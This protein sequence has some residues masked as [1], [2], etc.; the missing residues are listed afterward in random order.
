MSIKYDSTRIPLS[1][2]IEN[3]TK[4][5]TFLIPDL[6]RPYVWTPS[7]VIILIDS[8]FK[9]WPFGSLLLW[10]V[11]QDCYKEN[12]GIPHRPFW[13]VTDRTKDNDSSL[14][15][16][17]AQ[18]AT[19]HMVLDGQQRVQSLVLAL[20][21]DTWGF[22]LYDH[23]WADDLRERRM[24]NNI[25]W[26]MA[27]LC[28]DLEKFL[29]ELNNTGNKVRKI[30][31]GKILDWVIPDIPNSMS[32]TNRP[33]ANYDH[34]L[35]HSKNNSGRFIRLS[36]LWNEVQ[37]DLSEG[38]Y[39]EIIKP[40][41]VEH[42]VS[43]IDDILQPLAEFLKNIET[44][45][46]NSSVHVLKI[47]SFILTAQW[48]KD[49]YN[50][51]IVNIFTRLNTAGRTLTRE[52]ITLAWLKVG[53][54]NQYTNGKNA[55]DCF[56]KFILEMNDLGFKLDMD[57]V[58]RL[59]S[60]I[61]SVDSR[62]GQLLD[63]KD[64]LNGTL[65]RSMA[66]FLAVNWLKLEKCLIEGA[67]ILEQRNLIEVQGAFNAV[68]VYLT[69]YYYSKNWLDKQNGLI[70]VDR[71][72][73]EKELSKLS[74]TFADRWTFVSQWAGVWGEGSVKNFSNFART[75]SSMLT[76]LNK[77]RK[78]NALS[79]IIKDTTESLLSRVSDRAIDSINNISVRKRNRVHDYSKILWVWHRLEAERWEK[80][81]IQLRTGR[82]RTSKNEV[83]HT[84]ADAWW[85]NLIDSAMTEKLK[86]F[87]GTEEE[88][89]LIGP[90]GFDDEISAR[91]FINRL[92][93]CSLLDKSF[94]ISKS[95][96]TFWGFLSE[97]H[98]FKNG[99]LKRESWE[100]A[101]SFPPELTDPTNQPYEV[102]V[103]KI[104]ERDDLMKKEVIEF[105]K[106]I[107]ERHDL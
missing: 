44:I 57:D 42:S 31:V 52:E 79:Q 29:T 48:T 10:E 32:D 30:E 88:K 67:N 65:I 47:E 11:K 107:K 1:E 56:D 89:L 20:G 99:I 94:N 53:W 96:G 33:V 72:N 27:T 9:G 90:D 8:L 21:G 46:N 66:N 28:V 105:I 7:Q 40:I 86:S 2:I 69:W 84:V 98:D 76:E 97:V 80:S 17:M 68:I 5:A 3:A 12:E 92:G 18:P 74:F 49:D 75:L 100:Q 16:P 4:D 85:Q 64:L 71:D 45:K 24:K 36:R 50:D 63:S 91:E 34:P 26:S 41:L 6:Q 35:C 60:F 87:S 102:I 51:A 104:K 73:L 77:P 61:W 43:N 82:K 38:D 101:L 83:D 70:V 106:G 25:H 62:D 14:S 55:R 37:K 93:N 19:Y 58:V 39:R 95:A 81:S 54:D 78:N 103:E 23:E 15:S 59:L 13:Q 22:K